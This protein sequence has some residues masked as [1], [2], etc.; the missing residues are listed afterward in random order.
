MADDMRMQIILE[1]Q[2]QT[3][4]G[5]EEMNSAMEGF[6][7]LISDVS[8]AFDDF[9]RNVEQGARGAA[10][11]I[12]GIE[13]PVKEVAEK[14]SFS[15]DDPA[16]KVER[17]LA[18]IGEGL[19]PVTI[20][21]EEA[22]NAVTKDF[23]KAAE[24]SEKALRNIGIGARTGTAPQ[25]DN[26]L[27]GMEGS[28]NLMYGGMT[29]G[30][31]AL[32][33]DLALKSSIDTL[34]QFE[35]AVY[36]VASMMPEG[37]NAVKGM[38]QQLMS[39][40]DV[41]PQ[42]ATELAQGLYGIVG[43][44]VPA[45]NAMSVLE[46]AAE[47]AAGGQTDVATASNALIYVLDSYG[48]AANQA[49]KVSDELFAANQ[50][51]AMTFPELANA[52][53][54]VSGAAAQ[55]GI[56]FDQVAAATAALSNQGLSAQ[57]ATLGLR[58]LLVGIMAPTAQ[59]SKEAA[60]LGI[61]WDAATL[62]SK[63]LVGMLQEAMKAT[64]GN[65]E[66]LKKLIP[67]IA[68]WTVAVDLGGKGA[69]SY[70]QAMEAMANSTGATANAME[71]QEQS[72]DASINRFN[73][74]LADLKITFAQ[75]VMPTLTAALKSLE[76][77][78]KWFGSLSDGTKKVIADTLLFSAAFLT[79]TAPIMMF[80]SGLG[81]V[82]MAIQTLGFL[83]GAGDA[84]LLAE[85]SGKAFLEISKFKGLSLGGIFEGFTGSLR[86]L[87]GV[88]QQVVLG[89]WKL[90]GDGL[91]SLPGLI[92]NVPDAF[93]GLM[94]GMADGFTKIPSIISGAF[95]AIPEAFSGFLTLLRGLGPSILNL[96]R[97][98]F[99][100]AN[101]LGLVRTALDA[102]TGPWGLLIL[103]IAAGVGA[104]IEN[105]DKIKTW[106]LAHFGG[107]I[108]SNMTELKEKLAQIWASVRRT[109]E[110]AWNAIKK[111]VQDV[112]TYISPTIMGA[113]QKIQAFWNDV[114]PRL[115]ELFIQVWHAMEI[116]LAP[117]L[118]ALYVGIS[119]ALGLIKGIWKD[120]WGIIK[121][122]VKL[123]WD[124][125]V[126]ILRLAWDVVSGI[127]KVALDLLTGHWSDAW[128]D[129]KQLVFNIWNDIETFFKNLVGNAF[130]W[131]KN[132]IQGFVDG[133]KSMISAVSN[134]VS[135]VVQAAK[136]F[137]GFQSPSKEGPGSDA[138]TW[139]PNLV[140]M[141]ADGIL[142]GASAVSVA[143]EKMMQP[144]RSS[145][146]AVMAS[147]IGDMS[148]NFVG[149]MTH[150][151][152]VAGVGGGRMSSPTIYVNVQGNIAR[153]EHE[154]GQIVAREIWTQAKMQGKF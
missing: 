42:S 149:S 58:A 153:N 21:A 85:G 22:A 54:T 95:K 9:S 19:K 46:T 147:G 12:S 43:A 31:A 82:K 80:L 20:A 14:L 79:I 110:T 25:K 108:P 106:V 127:F 112:W 61:E 5:F 93:S 68:A 134:A 23:Q 122:T 17:E 100:P 77:L 33:L 104:I 130:Q 114:W 97:A 135:G 154:L 83:K 125:I 142:D 111:V 27:L 2:N 73:K 64:G 32:P 52:I 1:S 35:K 29:L 37:T 72:A 94:K 124:G 60:K 51:G 151:V 132:I 11:A 78:M 71:T 81:Q 90:L 69:D 121:S 30:A 146:A 116:A 102:I 47:A 92:K 133:I 107:T 13:K 67:N 109:F 10:E 84:A 145:V 113:V 152:A 141:F 4:P 150:N 6:Q 86:S 119:A 41:V 40:S 36:N 49:A 126:D 59:A 148:A 16:Q 101:I 143:A 26:G 56:S 57:R 70:K 118:I 139:A 144:L 89:P 88:L 63:G 87:G 136:N 75:Q 123:V 117:V 103:G 98:A 74:T 65:S 39:L 44:G 53:G 66:E 18:Q 138:D 96:L 45:A 34:A 48:M 137:I 76:D 24:E 140:N 105:W 115:K 50:S 120:A 15:F 128:N 91:R 129:A 38:E 99:N 62:K 8:R 3:S 55:A 7:K 28:M 131:G